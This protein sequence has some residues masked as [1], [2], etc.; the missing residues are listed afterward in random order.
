M[1]ATHNYPDTSDLLTHRGQST[2]LCKTRLRHCMELKWPSCIADD[3]TGYWRFHDLF[4]QWSHASFQARRHAQVEE[5]SHQ[6]TRDQNKPQEQ[7]QTNLLTDVIHVSQHIF[8][9]EMIS[10]LLFKRSVKHDSDLMA[11]WKMCVNLKL[12]SY[13]W[14]KMFE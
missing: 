1:L 8:I 6:D 7:I 12:I 10:H 9:V 14:W 11:C 4:S 13:T 3:K 5:I 2:H